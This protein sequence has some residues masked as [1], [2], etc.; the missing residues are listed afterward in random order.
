MG[1]KLSNTKYFD[2]YLKMLI[3]PKNREKNGEK[4]W[5]ELEE[6]HFLKTGLNKFKSYGT[7]RK[8]KSLY[9][10]ANR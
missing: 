6:W 1:C 8:E 4:I 3:N 10:A 7:F 9:Y 5:E 2:K